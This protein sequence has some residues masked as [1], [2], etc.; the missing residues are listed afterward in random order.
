MKQRYL[1]NYNIEIQISEKSLGGYTRS[2]AVD[3]GEL[4]DK[5]AQVISNI[6]KYKTKGNHQDIGI[7]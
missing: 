6:R 3:E 1:Q 4:S 7:M 2:E 5:I